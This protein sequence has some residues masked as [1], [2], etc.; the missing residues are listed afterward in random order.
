M[1]FTENRSACGRYLSPA[2]QCCPIRP[3]LLVAGQAQSS[4]AGRLQSRPTGQTTTRT[5]T[6]LHSIYLASL[7]FNPA[8]CDAMAN[9]S[10]WSRN[11]DGGCGRMS[12]GDPYDREFRL[13]VVNSITLVGR[14]VGTFTRCFSLSGITLFD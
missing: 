6:S 7:I 9:T 4:L 8:D 14:H 3:R 11:N 10:F 13:V 1:G 2:R 12:N 5:P